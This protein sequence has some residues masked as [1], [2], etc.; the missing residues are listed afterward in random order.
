[1][2]TQGMKGD[3][4]EH[5]A[6]LRQWLQERDKKKSDCWVGNHPHTHTLLVYCNFIKA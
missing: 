3:N 4:D 1:M 2:Y 5:D 6:M